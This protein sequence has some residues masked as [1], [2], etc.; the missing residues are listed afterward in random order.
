MEQ[1]LTNNPDKEP[2][3]RIFEILFDKDELTWQSIIQ[4]LIKTEQMDP[5]DVNISLLTKKYIETI[6]KLKELDF[7]VSGKVLLAAAILLKIKSNK[8][9]GEDIEYLDRLISSFNILLC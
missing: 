5:W 8:L 7:R 3:E 9:V 1:I 6:K 2:H 4:E